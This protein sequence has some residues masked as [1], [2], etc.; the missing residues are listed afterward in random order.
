MVLFQAFTTYSIMNK[1]KTT[2][3]AKYY[4][5]ITSYFISRFLISFHCICNLKMKSLL[6][7][8]CS[9]LLKNARLYSYRWTP[10]SKYKKK[11]KSSRFSRETE[12]LTNILIIDIILS[13]NFQN[14]YA[15]ADLGT[16]PTTKTGV[17]TATFTSIS[18]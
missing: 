7:I 14:I 5:Y 17:F 2:K 4:Q 15:E 12:Q 16:L 3:K 10:K 8:V 13:N 6:I 11:E 1:V 18:R 9:C